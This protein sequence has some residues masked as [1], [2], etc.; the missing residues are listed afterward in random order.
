MVLSGGQ[1]E[2]GRG[3][4]CFSTCLANADPPELLVPLCLLRSSSTRMR[5]GL[6]AALCWGNLGD[7]GSPSPPST[8]RGERPGC[9]SPWCSTASAG[10]GTELPCAARGQTPDSHPGPH[11]AAALCILPPWVTCIWHR[12]RSPGFP[13][14]LCAGRCLQMSLQE[15]R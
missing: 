4:G 12:R 15:A 2:R 7:R 5:C 14:S 8:A 11:R 3:A 6:W 9:P 13:L 10:L 1:E